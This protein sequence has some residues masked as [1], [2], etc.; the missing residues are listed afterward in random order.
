[1]KRLLILTFIS[2][3]FSFGSTQA[4]STSTPI[5]YI[6][7]NGVMRWSDTREE[8]S[9]FGVNYTLPFAHAYRAIGYLG[10]DRKAAIDKD[11]YHISRLG[12]NAYRIHLWDVELTD[13]QG[14]LLEN[15]HLDLM[16]Y[17]IAK[18]K[19]RNIHIVVTAQT[20]FG[21]GYPERNIPTGGFSYKYDKCDMH[22]NPEAIIA[23]E[24][25]LRDLMKHTNPY[26]GLAYKDDPSIVGFEI[27]NEP[28]H[29]GTKEEVKAY[30]SRM[31]KAIDK[32]GNRKP[33]FYNVSH[34]GY[35]VDA[36]YETA[37][38]GTTYQWYPI[39]LVSGQTQQG[40]FLPYVDRYDIPFADK[41]KGFNKKARMVYEFDPADIMY[42]YMYPAMVRTF[43]T[44]GFQWI[45]QFAYD[46]MDIAYANTEYQTHFLNLA[47]TPNKAVSMKIA[48]EAAR[49]LKRGES[50]GS[51]PQD[52][53]FSDGF[54]VSYTED[55]SELNN[56]EK[57]YYSNRTNTQPRDV[58]KLA[59]I[60]GCGSSPVV[61]YEGTGAYFVD[62]LESGVWRLEVMPDAVVV[63]DPFAKP[64]PDKEVVSI[65]YGAWD[66]ALQ[67]PDLGKAFTLT[68]LNKENDRKEEK[69]TDGVIRDL[70]PGVYLLKRNGCTPKQSWK[71][72]SQWNSIRIGEF[73]APAPRTMDY[74][75]THTP[76]T[77][78]EAG[79]AL[80]INAQVAG[81]VLPD[82]VIIYT[83][84]VS[85]WNEH[86]PYIKMKRTSGYTYQAILPAAEIKEGCF[87]YNIIVCRG[88]ST[89]TYPAGS[90]V[91]VSPSGI[92]GTPLN[93]DYIS[94]SYWTT[95]VVA[96]GSAIQL[97]KVTDTD[98][99]IEAYTLPE[100]N[101]LK[102]TLVDYSPVE[103]PLLRFRFTP[104]GENPQHFLRAFVKDEIEGR[105]DK[106]KSCT[107]LCIRVNRNKLLPQG[108][109]AGFVTSDGYTYK[110]L[111]PVPAVDGIIRIALKEL[112]Q[113]DTALLPIAYPT[114][115][116]QYFHPETEIPFRPEK[117]EKLELSMPGAGK[118]TIEVELGDVWLE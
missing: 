1:M 36:Y 57:F 111:C 34:N 84:K 104:E 86:N 69:I 73:A 96:S 15:E 22:S 37:I 39:G 42:S 85:F 91:T 21:N 110:S 50:Y 83:D 13:G 8:A 109:S 64:S 18:L 33:V 28:C 59:S 26:T 79:K 97:L 56:G 62:C 55:L 10:L 87:R 23:Q 38:Q 60:A 114:F 108:F 70:R 115:L 40:N 47:Y 74:K 118:P 44:A 19:E 9:F 27:N 82:S 78:V 66:M 3:L 32:T 95:R 81:N 49:S 17:L 93:W 61:G 98:S 99:R 77:T 94:D 106:V 12:L 63:N 92:K 31:L 5:I 88:D 107:T 43:R 11:V 35:V 46:P 41:V 54:R 58:S 16:D 25:Y 101:D 105:K 67:I 65:I 102:R 117:I 7:G 116:K 103:K 75:V 48:A 2:L 45:T 14:N 30:I 53:L 90:S 29:S 76:A 100:W 52:T 113:T 112:R 24:T 51:Y 89:R 4:K 80:T 20:N 68:A 71:A 6:D 72:D